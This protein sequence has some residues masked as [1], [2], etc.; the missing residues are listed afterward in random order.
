[1]VF[2]S[3]KYVNYWKLQKPEQHRTD[4]VPMAK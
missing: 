2:Y 3:E 1:M 4:P